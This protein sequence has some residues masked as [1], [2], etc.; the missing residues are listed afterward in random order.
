MGGEEIY[1]VREGETL[2]TISVKCNCLS[3]LDD[4]PQ[5]LDSDDLGPGTTSGIRC[6]KNGMLECSV[7]HSKLVSPSART[8]SRAY[9]KHRSK[10]SSKHRAL[11]VLLV[12]G[13][14]ILVGLQCDQD[15]PAGRKRG[16]DYKD[17]LLSPLYFSWAV[18]GRIFV[19]FYFGFVAI[20]VA[21]QMIL[22]DEEEN[23]ENTNVK[24]LDLDAARAERQLNR[25]LKKEAE[26]KGE[27][28][29]AAK[30]LRNVEMDEYDLMHWRRSL[31]EKEALIRDISV[32][33]ALGLPLEEPGR[34]DVNTKFW[35]NRYDPENPL[36]HYDYWGEPKNSENS[37]KQRI[38]DNHN[39]SIVGNGKV[40]Y[41]MS[42]EEC[43]KQRIRH[44]DR[45][46]NATKEMEEEEEKEE[47]EDELD[48]DYSILD[49]LMNLEKRAN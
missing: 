48:F 14:C 24:E 23:P 17:D 5:I 1:V 16:K 11:N 10:L 21:E 25:Q 37:R 42:Y 43:I 32:R 29:K 27:E 2:Q 38:A 46:K 12:I 4:N 40:W 47:E 9:D 39:K 18:D 22:D 26:E 33:K 30:L 15:Y 28:F 41:H 44:E 8:V 35:K 19:E 31:E 49:D 7:C 13:D 36:Y 45:M 34:Y 6:Q 20:H 3:I